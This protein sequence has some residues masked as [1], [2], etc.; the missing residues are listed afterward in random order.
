G[1]DQSVEKGANEAVDGQGQ[2]MGTKWEQTGSG[3][4]QNSNL[5]DSGSRQTTTAD[6]NT[7]LA[8]TTS[9]LMVN[10]QITEQAVQSKQQAVDNAVSVQQTERA[11]LAESNT[12]VLSNAGSVMQQLSREQGANNNFKQSETAQQQQN[13]TA[14]EQAIE[15]YQKSTGV[16]LT[17]QARATIYAQAEASG[18]F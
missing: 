4:I 3:N 2:R 18:G 7:L 9:Q 1:Y 8:Q 13:Y 11:Q 15:D 17:D 6:G 5:M 16:T 10:P 14:M 12:A